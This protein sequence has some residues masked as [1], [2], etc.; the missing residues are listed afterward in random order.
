MTEI[1][2]AELQHLIMA[3][4]RVASDGASVAMTGFRKVEVGGTIDR[5][6][7]AEIVTAFDYESEAVIRK[8]LAAIDSSICIVAEEAGGQDSGDL[9]WYVDPIDGTTNFAH[10]H[11]FWSVSIGLCERGIALAGVVIAPALGLTW[12]GWHQGGAFRNDSPCRVSNVAQLSD[13]LL[14][15]GFPYDRATSPQNNFKAFEAIQ[16]LA[17]GIRR[18]GSAAIDLCLVADG[19]Y[20]GYWEKKLRPWDLAAGIAIVNAAGGQTTSLQGTAV[21][22]QDGHVIASNGHIH[23]QLQ[24]HLIQARDDDNDRG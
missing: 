13:S 16:K 10:G 24:T 6:C 9:I 19:T 18:C 7:G 11:P 3:A 8:G 5:K 17:Q 21:Q 23:Q 14:A 2:N 1:N 22:L 4:Y 20:D 12:M 15:T